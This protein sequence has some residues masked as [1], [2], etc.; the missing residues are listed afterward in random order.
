MEYKETNFITNLDSI[1][2]YI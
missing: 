1:L 2:Q